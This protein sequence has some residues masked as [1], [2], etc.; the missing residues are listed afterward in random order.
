MFIIFGWL[1]ETKEVGKACA[2]YCYR[3]Q[4]DRSWEHWKVTEWVT[5]FTVKTIPFLSKSHVVCGSCRES[6]SLNVSQARYLGSEGGVQKLTEFI[7][8]HQ[9]SQKS[10]VQRRYLQSQRALNKS[11]A[12]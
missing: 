7:E 2:C 5:F 9:L 4:R 12:L 10:E 11:D 6:I 1:K 8:E 3:C